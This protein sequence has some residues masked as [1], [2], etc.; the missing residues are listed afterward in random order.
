MMCMMPVLVVEDNFLVAASLEAALGDAG[1]A[2]TLA[3]SVAEAEAA[4]AGTR[5]S[6]ALLDYALP[7]GDSLGL[8]RRLHAFGCP[9]AL[10]SGVDRDVVP[11]DAAIAARFAKPMDE[12]EVVE[13]VGAVAVIGR[14]HAA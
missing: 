10:V 11:L 14:S 12:R 5:F 13:W 8:A 6:A 9:V 7:D 3:R 4:L 2:V 1:H